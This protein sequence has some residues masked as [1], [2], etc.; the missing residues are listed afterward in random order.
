M[1]NALQVML[2][3]YENNCYPWKYK[4]VPLALN[5]DCFR[6]NTMNLSLQLLFHSAIVLLIGLLSG[7]PYG[8]AITKK[9]S[10][11]YGLDKGKEFL[12]Q[13]N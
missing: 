8:S 4:Q 6:R 1:I 2:A 10:N 9:K 3:F 12:A 11:L 5:L 13:L 7:I